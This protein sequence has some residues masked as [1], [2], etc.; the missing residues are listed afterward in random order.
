MSQLAKCCALDLANLLSGE[1]KP[2][3]KLLAGLL[4][5]S[6][7]GEPQPNDLLLLRC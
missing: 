2:L 7:D 3:R 6:T 5:I 4:T 1:G